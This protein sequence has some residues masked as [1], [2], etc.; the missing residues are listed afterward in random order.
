MSERNPHLLEQE[1]SF[2]P[3]EQCCLCAK[4][5]IRPGCRCPCH[6]PF[7]D[8]PWELVKRANTERDA[9]REQVGATQMILDAERESR[10]VGLRAQDELRAQVATLEAEREV[11]RAQVAQLRGVIAHLQA[12][13]RRLTA[14]Q[15]PQWIQEQ[16]T[17]FLIVERDALRAQ[18]ATLREALLDAHGV[19]L[20]GFQCECC[21]KRGTACLYLTAL[22]DTEPVSADSLGE[23]KA[24]TA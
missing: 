12:E 24:Q 7:I 5:Y 20:A 18:V 13:I 6:D 11:Q 3:D 4:D 1:A 21:R 10:A 15:P 2:M 16:A 23:L 19:L 14:R 9:L 17:A 8:S 22:A